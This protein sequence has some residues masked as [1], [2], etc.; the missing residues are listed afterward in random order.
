MALI[1][2]SWH[3]DGN[4]QARIAWYRSD[5]PGYSPDTVKMWKE[6]QKRNPE[7]VLITRTR[8]DKQSRVMHTLWT[9]P[10]YVDPVNS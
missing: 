8:T 10:D 5:T 1:Y 7:C 3:A 2:E 9:R 4:G 6:E